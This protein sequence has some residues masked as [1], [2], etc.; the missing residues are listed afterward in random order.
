M[1]QDTGLRDLNHVIIQVEEIQWKIQE[2][3]I[4]V[5]HGYHGFCLSLHQD[6]HPK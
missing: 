1:A 6:D 3:V 2:K 4:L 5:A